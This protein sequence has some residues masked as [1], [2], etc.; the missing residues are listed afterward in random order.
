MKVVSY[1]LG[2]MYSA[3]PDVSGRNYVATGSHLD[4]PVLS[5][6]STKTNMVE[7]SEAN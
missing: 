1:A 4:T 2:T 7:T 3:A 5:N 6:T